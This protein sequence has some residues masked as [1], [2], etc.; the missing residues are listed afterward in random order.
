MENEKILEK[1][2]TKSCFI[3]KKM[4]KIEKPLAEL[5]KKKEDSTEIRKERGEYY[6]WFY[7]NKKD[8]RYDE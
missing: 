8:Y 1:N 3:Q 7:R 6:N 4:N 2:E 5:L